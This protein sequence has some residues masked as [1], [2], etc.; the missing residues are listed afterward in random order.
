[1]LPLY[2]TQTYCFT[3]GGTFKFSRK[4]SLPPKKGV[5]VQIACMVSPHHPL[6]MVVDS[7]FC[8]PLLE[9]KPGSVCLDILTNEC[10][11]D[12]ININQNPKYKQYAKYSTETEG[13]SINLVET[14]ESASLSCRCWGPL[15]DNTIRG[16]LLKAKDQ[17]KNCKLPSSKKLDYI[18]Q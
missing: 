4:F 10:P 5:A 14:L 8:L 6:L 18:L 7:P 16:L 11:A 1:M 17:I 9:R 15:S 13:K 2:L 3:E 12:R